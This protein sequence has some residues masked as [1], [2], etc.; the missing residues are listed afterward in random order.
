MVHPVIDLVSLILVL[1]LLAGLSVSQ[2]ELIILTALRSLCTNLFVSPEAMG[3]SLLILKSA[4]K[5]NS[6]KK[7]P[8]KQTKQQTKEN[9]KP[10][11][12]SRE[13]SSKVG[14]R[15]EITK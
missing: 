9:P 6:K 15:T 10:T 11:E 5:D 2:R 12:V 7:S 3:Q 8:N 13:S 4:S 1:Q 14:G